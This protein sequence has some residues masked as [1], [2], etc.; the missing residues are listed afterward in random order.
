MLASA[1][2]TT[3]SHAELLERLSR[4]E[5][6]NQQLKRD[7]A[8]LSE[9]TTL[10]NEE[11]RWWKAQFFGR[12]SEKSASSVCPD[13]HLL[14]NEAEVLAAIAA[15]E[16]EEAA[17]TL[18]IE[19]HERKKKPGRKAIPKAFPRLVVTHD[20][21]E[22]QKICAH[23]GTPLERIGKET[24]EQY[25]YVPPQL[26]VLL[27]ERW[28][29]ACPCCHQGVKIAPVPAHILP[30]CM[31]SP[32]LL[33]QITTAK[34][35]D[36]LPL[37]RQSKQLERDGVSLGAG[38]LG[39]WLNTIGDEKVVPLVN[40]MNEALL[41]EPFIHCDETPLQVLKSPKSPS[42]DH[43]MWVRAAGPPGR[44]IVLFDYTP[45][46][47][48]QA[49]MRLLTG[50]DGPYRGKLLSDGLKIYDIVGEAWGLEMFGC[51]AHARRYFVKAQKVGECPSGRGLAEIAIRDH[52]GALYAVE[53]EIKAQ[54]V[55][56]EELGQTL[57]LDEVLQ[58]RQ[59]KASPVA[60]AFRAWLE[61]KSPTV[62]PQSALGKAMGYALSQWEKLVRYIAHPEI[63]ADNNYLENHIRPFAIG[64]KAW[65]FADTQR[66]ARA[67][68]NL[69]SL[70]TTAKAN[71][72]EP[73]QYLTHLY[74]ELPKAGTAEHLEA[75]LPWNV[76][77]RLA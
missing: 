16:G 20:L 61:E 48:A 49:L 66:G 74:T 69:Y 34:F 19:A 39:S 52:I 50:P 7:N 29:Y 41:T 54:R 72:L 36:G 77:A 43:F 37:T 59:H 42:S 33:A 6:E 13:Q 40:L 3:A 56:R 38:T 24:A 55:R 23:D 35:V 44:R 28:K 64:R 76:K 68:A 60:A 30:K 75:L 5:Q 73:R 71:G 8:H 53:R 11:L 45:T 17:Q 12:S 31:A 70:V 10:L 51:L 47:S 62:P 26:R 63:P 27:H 2:P 21:P 14:F 9:R 1:D 58:I 67:S 4:L 65:L 57:T 15:A 22:E 18:R 25:D 32:A 46:R